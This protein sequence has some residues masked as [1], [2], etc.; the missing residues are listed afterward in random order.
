MNIENRQGQID[1][2]PVRHPCGGIGSRNILWGQGLTGERPVERTPDAE[3]ADRLASME[4]FQ[5][6]DQASLRAL[7]S[8]LR[9]L[10]LAAG[11][12]L[13][14]QGDDADSLFVILDGRLSVLLEHEGG[15][16]QQLTE[17]GAGDVVGEVALIAGG[18]RS[19]IVTFPSSFSTEIRTST[20]NLSPSRLESIVRRSNSS[21][22]TG[23]PGSTWPS[24]CDIEARPTPPANSFESPPANP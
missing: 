16:R 15:E 6:L 17:L 22:N 10:Q 14:R 24:C 2:A 19:A 21:L 8:E 23:M 1:A 7:A 3:F 18:K 11:D 5:E 20:T 13:V 4:L 9:V 12:A